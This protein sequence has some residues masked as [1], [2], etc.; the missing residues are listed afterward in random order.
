MTNILFIYETDMPTVSITKNY[1]TNMAEEYQIISRFVP[2]FDVKDEDVNWSDVL[3]FIRPDNAFSWRIAKKARASGRFIIAFCDDDLLHRPDSQPDLS[4]RRNG[5]IKALSQSDVLIS[6]SDYL[7][8][9]MSGYTKGG[10][11]VRIDTV[12]KPEEILEREFETVSNEE[13]KMVYAAGAQHEL[14][15][16]QYVLPALK[17]IASASSQKLSITFIS[18]HPDCGEL[19]SLMEVNY[20][21][22][23]PLLEYRKYMEE[24]RFDLGFSPLSDSN[25]TKCKYFNKYLEYTLSGVVGIYSNV[26]PYTFV[27]QDGYNGFLAD[28]T[29]ESWMEKLTVAIENRDLRQECAKNAQTH[30]K[31]NF[32]EPTVMDRIFSKIPELRNCDSEKTVYQKGTFSHLFYRVVKAVEYVYKTVFYL[33]KEG[34]GSIK[35]KIAAHIR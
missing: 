11:A 17:E 8:N 3:F 5:L 15:F 32:D 1:W 34:I 23:M 28:N 33:R 35:A 9:Q 12:V 31:N 6:S 22:G 14:L 20:L 27:V 30:V 19:N 26:E 16:Q 10:R 13:I 2:L 21:S 25:F 29:V 24:Q 18:V 7:L 4:W